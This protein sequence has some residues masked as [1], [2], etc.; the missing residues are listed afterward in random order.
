MLDHWIFKKT[1]FR[2]LTGLGKLGVATPV[3]SVNPRKADN[4]V[5]LH[6]HRPRGFSLAR[7]EKLTKVVAEALTQAGMERQQYKVK[8]LTLDSNGHEYLVMLDLARE[9]LAFSSSLR[10]VERNIVKQALQRHDIAVHSVYWQ[11]NDNDTAPVTA[12]SEYMA[13]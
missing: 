8:L 4:V 3:T 13:A 2:N 1:S 12:T 10:Q 6:H 5:A 9:Y 11:F 7:R